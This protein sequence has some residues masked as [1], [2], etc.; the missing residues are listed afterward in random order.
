MSRG[1]GSG[2]L[3]VKVVLAAP[4]AIAASLRELRSDRHMAPTQT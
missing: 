2:S 1:S 4:F 3:R